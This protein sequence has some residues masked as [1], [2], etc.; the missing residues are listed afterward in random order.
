MEKAGYEKIALP[1]TARDLHYN[2]LLSDFLKQEEVLTM[3]FLV[4]RL[5]ELGFHDDIRWLINI[6]ARLL[7]TRSVQEGD[8]EKETVDDLL[9]DPVLSG[10]IKKF[11]GDQKL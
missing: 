10:I 8:K 2:Q 5:Q 6:A 3:A 7:Q 4:G 11:I 9:D 1:L